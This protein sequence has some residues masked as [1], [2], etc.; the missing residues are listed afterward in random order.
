MTRLK[1]I[2]PK[3]V[4]L[5]FRACNEEVASRIEEVIQ[6]SS[7]S[8]AISGE[9]ASLACSSDEGRASCQ[10]VPSVLESRP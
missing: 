5:T 4:K 9:W 6:R 1:K 10:V 8:R 2:P 7:N 3:K